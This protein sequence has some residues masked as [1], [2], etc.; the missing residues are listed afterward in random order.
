MSTSDPSMVDTATLL[1]SLRS[2]LAKIDGKLWEAVGWLREA[3]VT[4]AELERRAITPPPNHSADD[5][6]S[7]SATKAG[8]G[9]NTG[10]ED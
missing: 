3:R 5:G 1:G 9:T 2:D 6:G 7:T 10:K 8:S 4:V